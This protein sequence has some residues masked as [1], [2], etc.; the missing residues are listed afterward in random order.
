M[1]IIMNSKIPLSVITIYSSSVENSYLSKVKDSVKDFDQVI[2]FDTGD[3]PIHD[4]S[5]VRN[6][7]MKEA[8]HDYVLFIDSNEVLT[9]SSVKKIEKIVKEKKYDLVSVLRTDI[10][11]GKQ[12]KY[13]EAGSIHLVRLGKREKMVFTRAVHETVVI[14]SN[15]KLSGS[16]IELLHYSHPNLSSFLDKIS[17]YAYLESRFRKQKPSFGLLIELLFFPP[18]KFLFNFLIK[19][20]Y[21][22]GVRGFIYAVIMSLHSLFVRINLF[23][24]GIRK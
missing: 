19:Q 12:L 4:F 16:S 8:S 5:K 6:V 11:I 13:G 23:E 2:L 21:R 24:K 9:R 17:R 10:F 3:K 14:K 7:A 20:G 22:D 15:Y 1:F 18:L